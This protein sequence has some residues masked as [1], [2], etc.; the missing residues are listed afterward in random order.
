MAFA[1]SAAMERAVRAASASP[2]RYRDPMRDMAILHPGGA[3][4]PVIRR[5]YSLSLPVG[6]RGSEL[7]VVLVRHVHAAALRSGSHPF[8]GT[9]RDETQPRLLVRGEALV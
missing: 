3:P 8:K 7:G 4:A 6:E 2:T 1:G 5:G 9:H